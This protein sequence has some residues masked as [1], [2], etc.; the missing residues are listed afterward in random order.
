VGPRGLEDRRTRA[1]SR[2]LEMTGDFAIV[3]D[4]YFLA[5]G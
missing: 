4:D 3:N 2:L 1:F 5:V